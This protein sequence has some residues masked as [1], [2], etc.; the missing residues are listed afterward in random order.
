VNR[1]LQFHILADYPP[2]NPNRDDL[3]KPKSAIIGGTLRQRMSSQAIKRAV[4]K[5]PG[6]RAALEG[7]LGD[8]TQRMGKAVIDHL[9]AKGASQA[10][11]LE[12]AQEI[13]AVF[14]KIEDKKVPD[15]ELAYTKQLAFISPPE[16]QLALSLAEQAFNGEKLPATKDLAKLALLN[17]DG[18]G[19]VRAHAGR[20]P[21]I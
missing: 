5:Q 15:K 20:Q 9:V 12:I 17:A 14:G 8:R 4:R 11:A 2:S 10:R 7:Q 16:K 19:D 18:A 21:R 3:G 13:A 6:F 1:F